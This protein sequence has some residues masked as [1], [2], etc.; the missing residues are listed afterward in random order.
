MSLTIGSYWLD[1][2]TFSTVD[3]NFE[4][5]LSIIW[6]LVFSSS[7]FAG[8]FIALELGCYDKLT[9]GYG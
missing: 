2:L 3:S 4:V 8:G 6:F 7:V 9:S 1:K 5:S